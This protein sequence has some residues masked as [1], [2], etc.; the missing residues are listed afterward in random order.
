LDEENRL[1][2]AGLA[3]ERVGDFRSATQ[4]LEQLL[5]AYPASPLAADARLALSRVK[6]HLAPVP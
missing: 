2:Q 6:S 5:S 4:S 3:A 1:F